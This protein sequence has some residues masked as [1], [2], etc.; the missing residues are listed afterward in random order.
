[1]GTYGTSRPATE[2]DTIHYLNGVPV[3]LGVLVSGGVAL[4]VNN[5]TTALPF[6]AA[7]TC[8][9]TMQGTLAGKTLLLQPSSAGFIAVGTTPA[10]TIANQAVVPAAPGTVHGVAL[11]AGEKAIV[12]MRPDTGWL[13]WIPSGGAGNLFV[14]ELS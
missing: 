6:H 9:G 12:L 10:L 2:R 7:I 13:Q 8:P 14:W 4:P 1:M 11:A 5:A 3:E